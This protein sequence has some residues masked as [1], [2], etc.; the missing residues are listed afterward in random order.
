MA[1][2]WGTKLDVAEK[3]CAIEDVPYCVSRSS[4][5]FQGQTGGKIDHLNPIWVRL[6]GRSQLSNPSNS[7]CFSMDNSGSHH[8]CRLY[9]VV[10]FEHNVDVLVIRSSPVYPFS[11]VSSEGLMQDVPPVLTQLSYVFLAPTHQ[12]LANRLWHVCREW[13]TDG[14]YVYVPEVPYTLLLRKCQKS[15]GN[16]KQMVEIWRQ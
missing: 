8:A 13:S 9:I 7:P 14:M 12:H 10:Y 11:V 3:R 2:K 16:F 15:V 6:L 5:I 1:L 4:I